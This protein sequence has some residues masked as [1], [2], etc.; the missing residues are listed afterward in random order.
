M[1]LNSIYDKQKK[2][3]KIYKD[4]IVKFRKVYLI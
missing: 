2:Q 3:N 4:V 1:I